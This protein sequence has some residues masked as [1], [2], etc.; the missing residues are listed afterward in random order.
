MAQAPKAKATGSN[1]SSIRIHN[2][3]DTLFW[4]DNWL[5][6]GRLIDIAGDSGTLVMGIQR[7]ATVASAVSSGRWNLRRCRSSHLR[8][9]I[10]RINSAPPPVEE[11]ESDR[12]LWRQGENDYKPWFSSKNTWNQVRRQGAKVEWSKILWFSHSVPRYSFIAW[13][14]FHNRLSTGARTQTKHG[15]TY[16]SLVHTH[17][18]S[19]QSSQV[20]F[21]LVQAQTGASQSPH[22]Y[23][24]AGLLLTH[25]SFVSPSK[26]QST[27]FGER[28]TAGNTR[29]LI[30]Q[31]NNS[32]TS[33]TRPY[34]TASHPYAPKTRRPAANL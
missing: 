34:E 32:Y 11:A 23:R 8:A 18:R 31:P 5:D 14:A 1:F 3:K 33:S 19:G 29:G 17:I 6:L 4:F 26:L 16:S 25:V 10:A 27:V 20:L 15:I 21:F 12:L 24:P 28:G 13:L 9:M 2:G 22:C 30:A 7:Y